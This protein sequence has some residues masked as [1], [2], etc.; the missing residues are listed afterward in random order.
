MAFWLGF[1]YFHHRF[2]LPF[3]Q[4][5]VFRCAARI[6]NISHN[7][8]AAVKHPA[9]A[10]VDGETWR[11]GLEAVRQNRMRSVQGR[12][13]FF[14]QI[15]EYHIIVDWIDGTKSACGQCVIQLKLAKAIPDKT[16]LVS[17]FNHVIHEFVKIIFYFMAYGIP[18]T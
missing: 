12:G 16:M 6:P 10:V 5:F 14:W 18:I 2:P 9:V 3:G 17:F 8:I 1:R 4:C 11:H 15:C 7:Y 13:V